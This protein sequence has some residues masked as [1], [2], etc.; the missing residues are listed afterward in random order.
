MVAVAGAGALWRGV[1]PDDAAA[2]GSVAALS[3]GILLL[4]QLQ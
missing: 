2:Q 1:A 4:L 3:L